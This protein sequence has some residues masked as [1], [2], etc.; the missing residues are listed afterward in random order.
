MLKD[1]GMVVPKMKAIIIWVVH[2][3]VYSSEFR[4]HTTKKM[5]YNL[6]VQTRENLHA[7]TTCVTFPYISFRGVTLQHYGIDCNVRAACR[8]RSWAQ[9]QERRCLLQ[10]LS[11]ARHCSWAS[12]SVAIL[13]SRSV[14]SGVVLHL[15]VITPLYSEPLTHVITLWW[16]CVLCES[17]IYIEHHPL[18]RL[19]W[20]AMLQLANNG[21]D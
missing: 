5:N 20:L 3:Y 19:G 12:W 14:G 17:H 13:C 15:F 18:T 6:C 4:V 8:F 16:W 21:N 9:R 1:V 7:T 10:V 2:T 11:V